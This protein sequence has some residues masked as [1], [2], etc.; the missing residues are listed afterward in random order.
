MIKPSLSYSYFGNP[1]E[2]LQTL[3]IEESETFKAG[4]VQLGGVG[5]LPSPNARRKWRELVKNEQLVGQIKNLIVSFLV[6]ILL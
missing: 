6:K 2:V 5:G 1:T 4:M 3:S